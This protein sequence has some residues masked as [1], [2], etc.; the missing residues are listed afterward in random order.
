M[1]DRTR[2]GVLEGVQARQGFE[3]VRPP[4]IV[5]IPEHPGADSA[6]S[7]SKPSKPSRVY[8]QITQHAHLDPLA[9]K[10]RETSFVDARKTD[11]DPVLI[12]PP[13]LD[14]APYGRVPLGRKRNDARQGLIDQDP[15]FIQFLES[16]TN[17]IVKGPVPGTEVPVNSK[18][19]TSKVTPLIQHL[20]DKKAAKEA[21]K[22]KDKAAAK[23]AKQSRQTSKGTAPDAS[24]ASQK[25][26]ST[27]V[28]VEK[29]GARPGKVEKVTKPTGKQ[30][31]KDAANVDSSAQSTSS[32][33]SAKATQ[34]SSS[35]R[36]D[37]TVGSAAARMLQRDLGIRGG[38]GGTTRRG[39]RQNTATADVNG[40]SGAATAPGSA[41]Q[42]ASASASTT[43][44]TSAASQTAT[45]NPAILKRETSKAASQS[46]S[47]PVP[48]APA[49][50]PVAKTASAP[51]PARESKVTVNP[52]S[53]QAFLKH[54]NPSQ[55]ITEPLLEA[56]FATFGTISK[57]EIDKRKGF[58]YVD[59]AE[60]EGLQ[61]AIAASPVKVAQGNVQV[62]ERKERATAA[63]T[64][65]APGRGGPA[66]LN[67]RGGPANA[68]AGIRGGRAA[69][70]G[71]GG[72][73]RGGSVGSQVA[74]ASG[75]S[76]GVVPN[77]TAAGG[78]VAVDPTSNGIPTGPRAMT[79]T[80]KAKAVDPAPR[81]FSPKAASG[82]DAA[83]SV[84]GPAPAAKGGET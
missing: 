59:F 82:S 1:E 42:E 26:Q 36:A 8:L 79:T 5:S 80:G 4:P 10:V 77:E 61:K 24:H 13:A 6:S 64:A 20:R 57:V 2:Q 68:G 33:S 19:G 16:L 37:A 65:A 25:G 63:A 41:A 76:A 74:M 14:F 81:T 28:T 23:N 44:P 51:A 35:K 73:S 46:A 43:N 7:A 18:D 53:T 17:P 72:T 66:M 47:K 58:A 45:Q 60:P 38:R 83:T 12:G 34:T 27:T 70:G 67:A 50:K 32:A 30:G 15:E 48:T 11:S 62:L 40:A 78:A 75:A 49:P 29:K 71:R 39:P 22:E 54:A 69:R 52:T 3:R 84:S 56:A 55:G 21:A 9:E 31:K